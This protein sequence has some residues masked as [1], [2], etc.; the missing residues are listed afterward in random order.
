LNASAAADP[1]KRGAL[2]ASAETVSTAFL[3]SLGFRADERSYAAAAAMLRQLGMTRIQL[4]TNN[5]DKMESLR[6]TG[7]ERAGHLMPQI[8]VEGL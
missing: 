3:G 6:N 4:L 5:L 7:I 2:L 1:G 8:E